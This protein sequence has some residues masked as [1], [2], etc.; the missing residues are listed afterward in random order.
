MGSRTSPAMA[1]VYVPVAAGGGPPRPRAARPDRHAAKARATAA[2]H[3]VWGM[4]A[5]TR[6]GSP[7]P[8]GIPL[9]YAVLTRR[10]ALL[11]DQDRPGHLAARAPQRRHR[12]RAE[13]L[14]ATPVPRRQL[15][16]LARLV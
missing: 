6:H 2:R 16:Q 5:G 9:P 7:G 14:A 12:D 1:S 10:G 13:E 8:D 11:Q 3:D 4:S 15:E